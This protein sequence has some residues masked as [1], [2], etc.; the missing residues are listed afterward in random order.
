MT[1]PQDETA[2]RQR[3]ERRVK[4]KMGF[5]A[6][7]LVFGLVN[8]GLAAINL[9]SSPQVLWFTWSVFGWG[10]GLAAHWVAVYGLWDADQEKAIQA[11]MERLRR[12]G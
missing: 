10:I 6:H 3:A 8:T 2:L 1:S 7:A 4:A 11:E 5:R 12:R 9:M